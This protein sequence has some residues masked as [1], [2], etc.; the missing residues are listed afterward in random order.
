MVKKKFNPYAGIG[1]LPIIPLGTF[2]YTPK[3]EQTKPKVSLKKQYYKEKSD[4]EYS[5]KLKALRAEKS[6][7]NW[8][9]IN[10]QVGNVKRGA[11]RV[12]QGLKNA[13]KGVSKLGKIIKRRWK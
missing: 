10:K 7:E 13:Q 12:G 2:A 4:W 5:K 6:K 9:N 1:D 8:E 11:E 3:G